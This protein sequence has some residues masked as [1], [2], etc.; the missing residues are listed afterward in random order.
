M[1]FVGSY[2]V[3]HFTGA[4]IEEWHKFLAAALR[5]KSA[6]DLWSCQPRHRPKVRQN[7]ICRFVS[8]AELTLNEILLQTKAIYQWKVDI[9]RTFVVHTVHHTIW[10]PRKKLVIV[11]PSCPER[12]TGSRRDVLERLKQFW[13]YRIHVVERSG[14]V[15]FRGSFDCVTVKYKR[16][17]T[18][19]S[20][21]N[22]IL[23]FVSVS[24]LICKIKLTFSHNTLVIKIS[25]SLDFSLY[26]ESSL[27]QWFRV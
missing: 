14:E 18:S 24:M 15:A 9:G 10:I 3:I 5:L 23:D 17:R 8:W 13:M 1:E 12:P 20:L 16:A 27:K 19:A 25:A 6:P 21:M 7:Y 2:S 22:V 11:E 4:F 26:C